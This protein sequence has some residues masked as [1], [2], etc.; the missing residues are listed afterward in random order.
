MKSFIKWAGNKQSLIED[1]K[2][3]LPNDFNDRIYYEPF[4]GSGSV[5]LNLKPF[6][7][8][9]NDLN[10]C[11]IKAFEYFSNDISAERIVDSIEKI[12]KPFENWPIKDHCLKYYELRSEF[13]KLKEKENRSENDD[14]R[15]VSLFI[16][17]NKSA[18]N[19]LYRENSLGEMN[20]PWNHSLIKSSKIIDK[21]NINDIVSYLSN[22]HGRFYN[23]DAIVWL[24][25]SI[26][27]D[28]DQK[29]FI[30]LDPPYYN[31]G[32][33]SKHTQYLKDGFGE[34][35]QM[36]LRDI[37]A[38]ATSKGIKWMLSNSYNDFIMSLYANY[39]ID[40]IEAKRRISAKADS[41]KL[42]KEVLITNYQL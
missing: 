11:I 37:L 14:I 38:D 30:Y 35:E 16:I 19:G 27:K 31:D 7:F 32:E 26:N 4:L 21:A 28:L 42:V 18:F 39:R 29:K 23:E 25:Q 24:N 17:L 12:C 1:I 34:E 10:P 6:D 8:Y 3:Y 20:S 33:T 41:R 5:L 15:I 22:A 36:K 2:K 40:I 13:N 9:A